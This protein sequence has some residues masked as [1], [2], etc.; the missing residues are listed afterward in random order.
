MSVQN[1]NVKIIVNGEVRAF[2]L[3]PDC[4]CAIMGSQSGF[5]VDPG[6]FPPGLH[7]EI[8]LTRQ[9]AVRAMRNKPETITAKSGQPL[10]VWGHDACFSPDGKHFLI[11]HLMDGLSLHSMGNPGP[12]VYLSPLSLAAWSRHGDKIA[13]SLPGALLIYEVNSGSKNVIPLPATKE[14]SQRSVTALSWNQQGD[15][16]LCSTLADYP[17]LGSDLFEVIVM[18]NLGQQLGATTLP[19][20]GPTIWLRD[21]TVLLIT[22]SDMGYGSGQGILWNYRT[23]QKAPFLP[24]QEGAYGNVAYNPEKEILA[25]TT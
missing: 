7:V 24:E 3:T 13:C 19:N 16:I 1:N 23:G 20:L 17:D 18:D 15:K 6:Q 11:H 2:P 8:Y 25:Y 22:Y 14:G 5:M 10:G 12:P 9:G 4:F 21:E